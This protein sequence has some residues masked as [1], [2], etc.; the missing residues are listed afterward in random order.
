MRL[1][2]VTE[3]I[4]HTIHVFLKC[5]WVCLIILLNLLKWLYKSCRTFGYI[6]NK[7]MACFLV[8]YNL[9]ERHQ[10]G[11]IAVVSE[12]YTSDFKY[13]N[14]N[15]SNWLHI[16]YICQWLSNIFQNV[17]CCWKVVFNCRSCCCNLHLWWGK[18]ERKKSCAGYAENTKKTHALV[19]NMATATLNPIKIFDSQVTGT[20]L[21]T[22][23]L[24]LITTHVNAWHPEMDLFA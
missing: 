22:G 15:P 2:L 24:A 6:L 10:S 19:V 20:P 5:L 17:Q 7:V 14:R 13:L 16:G 23:R 3:W 9:L 12:T 1:N 11:G 18:K 21:G 8:A 4:G